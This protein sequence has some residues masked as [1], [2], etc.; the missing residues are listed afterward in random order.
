MWQYISDEIL[1]SLLL[2][3]GVIAFA[4]IWRALLN[5]EKERKAFELCQKT[6]D[7]WFALFK[8]QLS[9][10]TGE[11]DPYKYFV[12]RAEKLMGK[13][14][15]EVLSTS[16][17][18]QQFIYR[19]QEDASTPYEE[20][21][22]LRTGY[23]SDRLFAILCS[24]STSNLVR[25]TPPLHDLHELTMQRERG[26]KST[27]IFRALAPS[28]L[29]L[30]IFGTLV[31]VHN[32]IE[33]GLGP[34]GISKLADALVPGA[35]AV[36]F[37]VLVMLVRGMY[38]GKLA[39]FISAFDEYTLT[40]VLRFLQ[41][42]DQIASDEKK[43]N[44]TIRRMG[45]A[46]AHMDELMVQSESI[47]QGL[48]DSFNLFRNFFASLRD[49]QKKLKEIVTLSRDK[50]AMSLGI[51]QAVDNMRLSVVNLQ[52][53]LV[54]KWTSSMRVFGEAEQN[55]AAFYQLVGLPSLR[56][57][58]GIPLLDDK[59]ES[60]EAYAKS[61]KNLRMPIVEE[62]ALNVEK[63]VAFCSVLGQLCARFKENVRIINE[64]DNNIDKNVRFLT[65]LSDRDAAQFG[66]A[67]QARY[68]AALKQ[69]A[70]SYKKF[71]ATYADTV[72]Q[73]N[74]WV[75]TFAAMYNN[76]T[77]SPLYLKGWK[78]MQLKIKD[79]MLKLRGFYKSIVGMIVL[80]LLALVM[81]TW[82]YVIL[83]W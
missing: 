71:F 48:A 77:E 22:L 76:R 4:L 2:L 17:A 81:V 13:P 15:T 10:S 6:I 72:R 40:Q 53:I 80:G 19:S 83:A 42:E 18:V 3:V 60:L 58:A 21:D 62:S 46:K 54:E 9:S 70:E 33:E 35:L 32:R 39:N 47:Y 69:D 74:A 56:V 5:L 73:I 67:L 26:G 79:F 1:V 38:N 43:L 27:A 23:V 44:S 64:K 8:E 29:V 50:Y 45:Q 61:L 41:P 24:V 14:E 28:I 16:A 66:S 30:G 11:Q 57:T 75:D 20:Q 25:V 59:V 7:R 55:I 12:T 51:M 78:G 37:T 63:M 52:R 49:N 68:A 36:F 31:G 82:L 65:G 34:E